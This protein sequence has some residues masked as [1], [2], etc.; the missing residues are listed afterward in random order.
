L[1]NQHRHLVCSQLSEAVVAEDPA[2]GETLVV[3]DQD[4]ADE[5]LGSGSGLQKN[6]PAEVVVRFTGPVPSRYAAEVGKVLNQ[7]VQCEVVVG[8]DPYEPRVGSVVLMLG[9]DLILDPTWL[10]FLLDECLRE[11]D[12]VG[13]GLVNGDETIVHAGAAAALG[14]Y[15]CFGAGCAYGSSQLFA[16]DRSGSQLLAPYAQMVHAPG[17]GVSAMV[18]P[19]AFGRFL[20][21]TVARTR[22]SS[23]QPAELHGSIEEAIPNAVL[24]VGSAGSAERDIAILDQL[25][26][27]SHPIWLADSAVELPASRLARG[28]VLAFEPREWS[29]DA[30]ASAFGVRAVLH[31]DD[32]ALRDDDATQQLLRARPGATWA[33][34]VTACDATLTGRVREV[35]EESEIESWLD[36]VLANEGS[37]DNARI[38][39]IPECDTTTGLVSVVVPVHGCWDMTQRCLDS[40]LDE[41]FPELEIVVVDDASPDN[42]AEQLSERT[43]VV[44]VSNEHNLGFPAAVNR[45]IAR[46]SGEFVCVLNN[47]TEVTPGWLDEM[48]A[49]LRIDGTAM[50]G[51]RSNQISGL[52]HVT[53][54][55][56]LRDGAAAHQWALQWSERRRGQSWRTNRLVGFCLLTRRSTLVE[57]GGLD[58]AFGR[59]NFEDDELCDRVLDS[60]GQLRV[61]DGAVVLHH[62]S[63]TFASLNEDFTATL[64]SAARHRGNSNA[65]RSGVITGIV[66]SDGDVGLTQNTVWSMLGLTDHIRVVERAGAD[67]SR[68]HLARGM[69]L[70][71]EV[72]AADWQS[73]DGAA[74]SFGDLASEHVVMLLSGEVLEVTDWGAARAEI[75]RHGGDGAGINVGSH[76]EVRVHR[77]GAAGTQAFGSE[78][79]DALG[80]VR[81]RQPN[82]DGGP[83]QRAIRAEPQST[84]IA[85]PE[86][87]ASAEP[88]MT[89]VAAIILSDGD[90]VASEASA[91][92]VLAIA[93]VVV[94][95]ERAMEPTSALHDSSDGT[96][97]QVH[98][99]DWTDHDA[100]AAALQQVSSAW[101]L[102]LEAGER[103]AIDQI[104]WM[105]DLCSLPMQAV[106]LRIGDRVEVRLTPTGQGAIDLIGS[107]TDL[108]SEGIRIVPST[109][110]HSDIIASR[111]PELGAASSIRA[112]LANKPEW[113]ERLAE[114]ME[115]EEQVRVLDQ[116][117][118]ERPVRWDA[119]PDLVDVGA[120]IAFDPRSSRCGEFEPNSY[121]RLRDTITTA[122]DQ[123]HPLTELI[124]AVPALT[125]VP[126]YDDGRVRVVEHFGIEDRDSGQ[127]RLAKLANL[128]STLVSGHWICLLDVGDRL[129][130]DHIEHLL[131]VAYSDRSEYVHGLVVCSD[132]TPAKVE[133]GPDRQL[134]QGSLGPGLFYGELRALELRATAWRIPEFA[135]ANRTARWRVL[136]VTESAAEAVTTARPAVAIHMESAPVAN[137]DQA[138]GQ[139]GVSNLPTASSAR[140]HLGSGPNALQGWTNIDVDEQYSPEL[141]HDLSQGL[142]FADGT[143]EL[144]YSEHFFEHLTL[145]DGLSLLK[146]C[147]RVLRPGARLRIAMPDL[148]TVINA[149]ATNWRDQVWVKDF[150]ELTSAAHMLNFALREWG[151]Q[152][153]Y[154]HDDL[155]QR[156]GDVG[157]VDIEGQAWGESRHADLQNRETR[158]DSL[159]IVECSNPQ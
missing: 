27:L 87:V 15:R 78:C 116:I 107:E 25:I 44:V 138:V 125:V 71:V 105:A 117:R 131:D 62:G 145:D 115:L 14:G 158:P 36:R 73:V 10:G 65:R 33:A 121:G 47:D 112:A 104:G 21:A 37:A 79:D 11:G 39:V 113:A 94:V 76:N 72:V 58:E 140:L 93:D 146:E 77:L 12:A 55:P 41:K 155:V 67:L 1:V 91:D 40:L 60:G 9:P 51:P 129:R 154:D 92:S 102:V 22:G 50:V 66:L 32:S 75:E 136:G 109:L 29:A 28:G 159:L 38:A 157:F 57:L 48:L 69:R 26:E 143:I 18:E 130:F 24:V 61:A 100:L 151:H 68:L 142:P 137:P 49:I 122:L 120:V 101:T 103:V 141:V 3:V 118:T 98:R 84:P 88:Q 134:R 45:G 89:L 144:I 23:E 133:M 30:L 19:T 31:L 56:S 153:V 5:A 123:S 2:A 147:K 99:V 82:V 126:G 90:S 17:Q 6:P 85:E 119:S 43:D 106:G 81:I 7:I 114:T 139:T 16:T 53:D 148:A 108:V 35:L 59:G 152:Y 83:E 64:A 95:F 70:G 4:A 13:I 8:S 46:S 52:Q 124:V 74:V 97:H 135:G 86:L 110:E 63:A 42:T 96:G 54:S 149:Y 34:L 127:A 156:L 80:A 128:G 111:F 20:G 132:V 150:P